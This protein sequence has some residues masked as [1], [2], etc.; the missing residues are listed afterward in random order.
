MSGAYLYILGSRT[1]TL[2]IGLTSNLCLRV[3]QHKE[4]AWEGFKDVPVT[5]KCVSPQILLP[6]FGGRKLRAAWVK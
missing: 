2:Y 6:G 3:L 1:G 4:G 5:I